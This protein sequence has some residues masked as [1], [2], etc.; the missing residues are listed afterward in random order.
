MKD[1]LT[2]I[3]EELMLKD[4]LDAQAD[5]LARGVGDDSCLE[6]FPHLR[7]R[8][9]P[10]LFVA[11]RLREALVLVSPSQAFRENL[12]AGLLT[13]ARQRPAPAAGHPG[14]EWKP[15]REWII[16]A[17]AVGSAVSLA[18]VAAF[19]L[20]RAHLARHQPAQRD[21]A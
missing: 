16:G 3:A 4:I 21:A 14:F 9:E 17:A 1:P 13:A 2:L 15:Q 7:T 11:R 10:L 19:F 5:S 20:R 18:S 12:R 8:L 6:L